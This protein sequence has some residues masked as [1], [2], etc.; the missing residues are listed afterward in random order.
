MFLVKEDWLQG[1]GRMNKDPD[2]CALQGICSEYI[3]KGKKGDCPCRS[4]EECPVGV[5]RP[6]SS[7]DDAGYSRIEVVLGEQDG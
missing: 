6:I 7:I 5:Y 4:V 3:I 2:R 1:D